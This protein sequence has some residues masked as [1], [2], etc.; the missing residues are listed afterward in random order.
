[1]HS[2]HS[3]AS[4]TTNKEMQEKMNEL[5]REILWSNQ[6]LYSKQKEINHFMKN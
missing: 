3:K 5:E 2:L 1:M 6:H 4:E